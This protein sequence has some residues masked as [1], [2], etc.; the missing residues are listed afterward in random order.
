MEIFTHYSAGHVSAFGSAGVDII[1]ESLTM[2]FKNRIIDAYVYR[3]DLKG[4]CYC[5]LA[6]E[7]GPNL[8]TT[9]HLKIGWTSNNI[10]K[11][12]NAQRLKIVWGVSETCY[13]EGKLQTKAE[14]MFGKINDPY[15]QAGCTEMFG[16][17]DSAREANEGAL[18]LL[19]T[20]RADFWNIWVHPK[21]IIPECFT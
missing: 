5:G 16:N 12:C 20:L 17:F 11:R 6:A 18:R 21:A 10:V 13:S 19:E 4:S 2:L 14:K 3:P 8:E 1:R 9:Y 15:G 7:I